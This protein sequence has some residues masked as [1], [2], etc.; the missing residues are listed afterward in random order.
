MANMPIY[1]VVPIDPNAPVVIPKIS[2]IPTWDSDLAL[3]GQLDKPLDDQGIRDTRESVKQ[4]LRA[5]DQFLHYFVFGPKLQKQMDKIRQQLEHCPEGKAPALPRYPDWY[6]YIKTYT[7]DESRMIA[8]AARQRH[9][10]SIITMELESLLK[11]NPDSLICI[12]KDNIEIRR[13]NLWLI[14]MI[15]QLPGIQVV[16]KGEAEPFLDM[17]DIVTSK[18]K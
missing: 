13:C 9:Y 4:N 5:A 2:D 6:E 18:R 17:L 11:P 14:D 7:A 12:A 1:K 15:N 3:L 8:D 10:K 16:A